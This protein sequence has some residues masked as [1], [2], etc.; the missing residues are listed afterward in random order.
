MG[1]IFPTGVGLKNKSSLIC[2]WRSV[3]NLCKNWTASLWKFHVAFKRLQECSNQI[4]YCQWR[5]RTAIYAS[6]IS[7]LLLWHCKGGS[8]KLFRNSVTH[9]LKYTASYNKSR[10][11]DAHSCKNHK[12]LILSHWVCRF[13]VALMTQQ[14]TPWKWAILTTACRTFATNLHET[15]VQQT[16]CLLTMVMNMKVVRSFEP[17][18]T[19]RRHY[20][21]WQPCKPQISVLT[22]YVFHETQRKVFCKVPV[23]LQCVSRSEKLKKTTNIWAQ[24]HLKTTT[25]IRYPAVRFSE[26]YTY[27]DEINR[28]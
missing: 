5:K 10:N 1:D 18:G 14:P 12:P 17:Y 22:R 20:E 6:E 21:I 13:P 24:P 7:K 19:T 8:S 27:G 28:W 2:S 25:L 23:N 9:W 16:N 11:L 4:R 15:Q 3:S 26:Y